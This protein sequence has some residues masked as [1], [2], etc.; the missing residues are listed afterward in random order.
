M[1]GYLM[2]RLG[3]AAFPGMLMV[4][5]LSLGLYALARLSLRRRRASTTES[6]FHPM[7]RTTPTAMEMLPEAEPALEAAAAAAEEEH[8]PEDEAQGAERQP[9]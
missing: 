5:Q 4:L 9:R 1:A 3:P 8:A 2:A 7:L 6:H